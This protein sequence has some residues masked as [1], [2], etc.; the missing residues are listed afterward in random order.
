[1]TK[2]LLIKAD[3][4]LETLTYEADNGYPALREAVGGLIDCVSGDANLVGYVNDEG[5]LIG[6]EPNFVASALFGRPLVGN[7]VVVSCVSP[8]GEYDGRDYDAPEAL[9]TEAFSTYIREAV[10]NNPSAIATINA[11]IENVLADPSP[12]VIPMT[13][14]E[15]DAWLEGK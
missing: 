12:K 10:L 1:M 7:C 13:E 9:F 8:E 6:L 2:A 5:L 4:E 15:F 14:A 3:G 11:A